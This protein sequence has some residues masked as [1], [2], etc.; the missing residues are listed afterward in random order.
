MFLWNAIISTFIKSLLTQKWERSYQLRCWAV[1]YLK[2]MCLL[3]W[4]FCSL[5]DFG[6][7]RK[8]YKW[9]CPLLSHIRFFVT[10]WTIA[11]QAPL[12]MGFS[13]QEYWSGLPFPSPGNLPNPGLNL[14]LLHCGRFFTVW[15]IREAPQIRE[16]ISNSPTCPFNFLSKANLDNAFCF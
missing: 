8:Q 16:I 13:R 9:E 3:S 15:V 1:A 5:Y 12:S 11:H 6:I 10:P 14:C 2:Y 4:P 7:S